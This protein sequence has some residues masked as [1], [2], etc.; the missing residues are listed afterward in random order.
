MDAEEVVRGASA[1]QGGRSIPSCAIALT[2]ALQKAP[3]AHEQ[4]MSKRAETILIRGHRVI[5]AI[6]AVD[7]R[8]RQAL[9]C[10]VIMHPWAY[11]EIDTSKLR[12][13]PIAR[14]LALQLKRTP[15]STTA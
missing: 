3:P 8:Q 11:R 6:A 4:L 1:R 7:A 15:P 9:T 10:Q 5:R 14:C 12:L 13:H 2:A